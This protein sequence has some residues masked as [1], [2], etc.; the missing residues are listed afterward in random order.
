MTSLNLILTVMRGPLAGRRFELNDRS[1][2]V[3]GRSHDCHPRLPNDW[4]H[5]DISRHHCVLSVEVP[6]IWL[7]DLGSTNGTFVN[8]KR[9]GR[10]TVHR[11]PADTFQLPRSHRYCLKSG[12]EIGLGENV[13]LRLDAR[14]PPEQQ[15]HLR[16]AATWVGA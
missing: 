4:A 13:V 9:I 14:M 10:R 6:N 1:V 12:D 8:G 11:S 15:H 3:I 7:Q 16:Q 5:L 2:Y